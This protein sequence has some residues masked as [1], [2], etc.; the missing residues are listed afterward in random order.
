MAFCVE[1]LSVLSY[2]SGFTLWLY[3]AANDSRTEFADPR[4]FEAAGDILAG[5][6]MVMVSARDGG[7]VLSVTMDEAGARTVSAT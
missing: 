7:R 5:G 3:K 4:F 1:N 6:D 2:S